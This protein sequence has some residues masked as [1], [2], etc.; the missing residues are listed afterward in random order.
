MN[1]SILRHDFAPVNEN[2]PPTPRNERI[3]RSKRVYSER[4]GQVLTS[5]QTARP[6]FADSCASAVRSDSRG[7]IASLAP[8]IH[9]ATVA[10]NSIQYCPDRT[11]HISTWVYREVSKHCLCH[12]ICPRGCHVRLSKFSLRRAFWLWHDGPTEGPGCGFRSL[13]AQRYW[14]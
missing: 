9:L 7:A 8:R 14:P 5:L 3:F 1:Q 10:R 13:S 2:S 6:G 4:I 11:V 12:A